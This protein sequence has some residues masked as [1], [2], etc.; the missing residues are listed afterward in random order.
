MEI[1]DHED[2]AYTGELLQLQSGAPLDRHC[3]NRVSS[4]KVDSSLFGDLAGA[5]V[6]ELSRLGGELRASA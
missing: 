4:A 2:L 6:E 5:L 1:A 3:A